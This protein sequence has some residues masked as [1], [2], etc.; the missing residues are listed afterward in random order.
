MSRYGVL[1]GVIISAAGILV[2]LGLSQLEL[3]SRPGYVPASR[4]VRT[5]SFYA[6]EKWLGLS[7]HPVRLEH[8]GGLP[9][10]PAGFIRK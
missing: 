1:T 3:Y 8:E 2:L 5:N 6:L 9:R 4:E 10:D 7:G